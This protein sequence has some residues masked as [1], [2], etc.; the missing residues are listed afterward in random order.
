MLKFVS[1]EI[2]T[3]VHVRPEANFKNMS[4]NFP[5]FL[6]F[7]VLFKFLDMAEAGDIDIGG[8]LTDWTS[9]E[10]NF[11]LAFASNSLCGI[12]FSILKAGTESFPECTKKLPLIKPTKTNCIKSMSLI[13]TASQLTY[14][15]L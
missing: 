7:N 14:E 8:N 11:T 1:K 4:H 2:I 3:L 13:C 5:S 9:S 10:G 6:I 15:Q 12:L